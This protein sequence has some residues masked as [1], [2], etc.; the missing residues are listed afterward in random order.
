MAI[1]W[2]PA[3]RHGGLKRWSSNSGGFFGFFHPWS[4]NTH[5]T[6]VFVSKHGKK[7]LIT[8]Q[9]SLRC[10]SCPT[11]W[12]KRDHVGTYR[13]LGLAGE[14]ARFT[15]FHDAKR[16]CSAEGLFILLNARTNWCG[17]NPTK[18]SLC[19]FRGH[20]GPLTICSLPKHFRSF[21]KHVANSSIFHSD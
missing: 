20:H 13:T 3:S 5:G 17:C 11:C 7:L 16:V 19:L 14:L 10:E 12:S 6:P 2:T 21:P 15:H 4:K 18:I 9:S 8:K 1:C